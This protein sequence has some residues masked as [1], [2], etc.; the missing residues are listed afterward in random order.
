M[1]SLKP[2]L[3]ILTPLLASCNQVNQTHPVLSLSFD[4][5]E[6]SNPLWDGI[7]SILPEK[8]FSIKQTGPPN[9]I[10]QDCYNAATAKGST[11]QPASGVTAY[12]ITFEDCLDTPL[13]VCYGSKAQTPLDEFARVLSRVP[14]NLRTAWRGV[15]L[16]GGSG[17]CGCGT[18]CLVGQC[19]G[20]AFT[21]CSTDCGMWAYAALLHENC[22]ANDFVGDAEHNSW[23]TT[24]TWI[25][26]YNAD[27]YQIVKD[28]NLMD[29]WADVC[30]VSYYDQLV[31]NG[32]STLV[33]D[34][35]QITLVH[36]Q[37]D[38]VGQMLKGWWDPK[39]KTCARKV[40]Y[41]PV[42]WVDKG[43]G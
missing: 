18:E 11:T 4:D 23:F 2:L 29:Y 1:I 8:H 10:P 33:M 43:S 6:L 21:R 13:L 32:L 3:L 24:D 40:E 17:G 30:K 16:G 19:A 27:T 41:G 12:S 37:I 7:N 42:V 34:G 20:G 5:P 15:F 35:L 9:Q 31:P 28:K 22:H 25:N 26:A 36:N 39:A 38:A 14:P